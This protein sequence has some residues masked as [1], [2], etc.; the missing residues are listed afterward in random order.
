MIPTAIDLATTYSSVAIFRNGKPEI[1]PVDGNERSMPSVVCFEEGEDH[2]TVGRTAKD[3]ITGTKLY[4]SKRC[5]GRRYDDPAI[6]QELNRWPFKIINDGGRPKYEFTHSGSIKQ[7]AP[8]EISAIILME[9]K[10]RAE[11]Y[12]GKTVKDVVITVPSYFNDQQRSATRDSAMIAGLNV[13]RMINEP[14]AAAMAYGLDKN[15]ESEKTI[16]IADVGGG[17][18]DF[19]ILTI[20]S[21]VFEVLST[22]G[23]SH[24]G[25]QDLDNGI[26]EHIIDE[27]KRK[28][29]IDLRPLIQA[30]DPSVIRTIHKMKKEAER[31]KIA[32]SGVQQHPIF[33]ENLY[34][35]KD[36]NT[37]ITRASFEERNKWFFERCLKCVDL[38]LSD[39]KKSKTQIDEIVLVGGTTRIPKFQEVLSRHFNNKSLCKSINPDEAI[40]LGAAIQAGI[41]MKVES[42]PTELLL[43]DV[44]P[45]SL[46]VAVATGQ[47]RNGRMTTKM[48]TIIPRNTTIP[49][50]KSLP[51]QTGHPGQDKAL[52]EILEGERVLTEDNKKLGE[53]MLENLSSQGRASIDIKFNLDV[54]G[55]LSVTGTSG[56]IT[57][58]IEIKDKTRYTSEEIEEMNRKA[59]NYREQDKE[60]ERK[61]EL[62][63]QLQ[64]IVNSLPED[65]SEQYRNWIA[66]S[67]DASVEDIESKIREVSNI[68]QETAPSSGPVISEVD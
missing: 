5:I 57:K 61:F 19:T 24:L 55:I 6:Q 40:A 43:L 56:S 54:N 3:S 47:I 10:K 33:I 30:K 65:K 58:T 34:S 21:G 52:I 4:D 42:A 12:S 14:T 50:Q 25:G 23:D 26:V 11:D 48:Q 46:G 67:E 44:C 18:S 37:T 38:A 2:P 36:L 7:Y 45:L 53:F 49:C 63:N 17:T 29:K 39:S 16:L 22:S 28:E 31:V 32:L 41:L 66:N 64:S 9:L 35:G 60:L 51:F 27:F 62:L 68:P 8:E 1:V 15:C 13:I 59:E 20:D